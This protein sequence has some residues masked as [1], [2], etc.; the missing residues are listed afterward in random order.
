MCL[1]QTEVSG[2]C[3]RRDQYSKLCN[4]NCRALS[5]YQ[6]PY[7]LTKPCWDGEGGGAVIL[8]ESFE[9]CWARQESAVLTMTAAVCGPSGYGT[10]YTARRLLTFRRNV[11]ALFSVHLITVS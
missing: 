6:R 11:L 10:V 4:L 3:H 1:Q 9:T 8:H 5:H 7:Y 2:Q